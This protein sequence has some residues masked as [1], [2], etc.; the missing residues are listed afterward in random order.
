MAEPHLPWTRVHADFDLMMEG[1]YYLLIMDH[2]FKWPEI[3]SRD[4]CHG[5]RNAVHVV[6]IHFILPFSRNLAHS[7]AAVPS[8]K[9]RTSRTFCG[10]LQKRTCQAEDGGT[11]NDALQTFM[12]AYRSTSTSSAP[13]QRSPAE[14][15]LGRQTR[16]KL[17][18]VLP[19]KRSQ[20]RVG[21]TTYTVRCGNEVWARHVDQLRS[22]I[23][24][25]ATNNF[26]DVFDL[27]LD[28]ASKDGGAMPTS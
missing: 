9:Q 24:T 15:F 8:T 25:T 1:Q 4:A 18:L 28:S 21:N 11:N 23:A 22:R 26:L 12:M 19:S 13:D 14:A 20:K 2:Y 17:D 16:T 10:H 5:Q 7:H 27:P 6:S 3:K